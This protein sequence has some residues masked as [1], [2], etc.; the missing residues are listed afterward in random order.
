MSHIN[1]I[2]I[3]KLNAALF[4]ELCHSDKLSSVGRSS[5]E[6]CCI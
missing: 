2:L 6:S 3:T 4:Y 5:L 1:F